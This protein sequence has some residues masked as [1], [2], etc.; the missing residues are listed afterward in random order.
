MP[1]AITDTGSDA[2]SADESV[3]NVACKNAYI[4]TERLYLHP[5]IH[6]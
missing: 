2:D 4:H 1:Q 6:R 5:Y 3:P